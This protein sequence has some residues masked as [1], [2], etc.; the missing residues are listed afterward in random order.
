MCMTGAP[1]KIQGAVQHC[2]TRVR[3]STSSGGKSGGNTLVS[4][5]PPQD[6]VRTGAA[7]QRC[8]ITM[9]PGLGSQLVFRC[10]FRIF[11]SDSVL[12]FWIIV[13]LNL[14]TVCLCSCSS[15]PSWILRLFVPGSL[16]SKLSTEYR[17]VCLN[18]RSRE[19]F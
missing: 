3:G 11:T 13:P 9:M 12:Y 8:K 10:D 17:V 6:N 18:S 2:T 4:K 15:F 1:S 16:L 19:I 14:G 5:R 7:D